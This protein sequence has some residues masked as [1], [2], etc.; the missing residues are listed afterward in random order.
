MRTSEDLIA[1][2]AGP[3]LSP[4]YSS[5]PT[6]SSPLLKLLKFFFKPI[7]LYLEPP[8]LLEKLRL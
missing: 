4:R 1:H 2:T 5:P 8:Y 3:P 6:A 7:V